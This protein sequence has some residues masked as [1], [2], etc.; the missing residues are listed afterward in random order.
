MFLTSIYSYS[1]QVNTLYFMENVPVRNSLNPAFQPLNDFY[2]G[3]PVL[4]LTQFSLSNNSFVLNDVI[5]KDAV[6]NPITFLHPN[7]DKLLFLNAINNS[8]NSNTD[9][10]VNLL[11]FGFRTGRAYWSLSVNERFTTRTSIPSDIFKFMLFG[12]PELNQNSFDFSSLSLN[13]TA[14]TE[15]GLG[16]SIKLNNKWSV[17]GKLKI[18][19]GTANISLINENLNF[20]ANT[21]EWVLKGNGTIKYS[22]PIDLNGNGIQTLNPIFPTSIIDYLKPSGY[23][24]GIDVGATFQ[25]VENL[26]FSLAVVDLGMIS[27]N[28]NLKKLGYNV[29]FKYTGIDSLGLN[30]TLNIDDYASSLLNDLQNSYSDSIESS[31]KLYSTCLSPKLNVGVEYGFFQ[32]KLSL[33]LLSRTLLESNKLFE[34]L[35]ASINGR[36][37]NWFNLSASYSVINGRMSNIGAGIGLRAGFLN[38]FLT[39]DYIPLNYIP[40]PLNKISSSLP[41]YS[42]LIPSNTKGFNFALG[43]N[44]VLGNRKDADKDGVD[45]KRDLCPGTPK[46]VKVNKDGCPVDTDGDGV[47]DYLDKCAKTPP[48]ASKQVDEFGCPLDTDKD[49]VPDYLDKCPQSPESA[50]GY[51]D[52]NG[53]ENDSDKDGKPDWLDKCPD[54]PLGV[55]VDSVGCPLDSDKDGIYDTVDKCPDTALKAKGMVDE[56]GCPK[57]S[58]GDGVPDYLDLCPDVKGVIANNGCEE[59]IGKPVGNLVEKPVQTLVEREKIQRILK[60]LFQKALQGIWFDSGSDRIVPGSYKIL[61]QIAGVLVANP[62]YI[63]EI[64][65][66]TD[67][68]GR[69]ESNLLL[70]KKRAQ[71]VMKYFISKG[72][73]SGRLN[74]NGYGEKFPVTDNTTAVGRG[75][76]RRVEFIVSYEEITFE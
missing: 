16:Y 19:M 11:D 60:S 9:F 44:L 73:D 36:P 29:D 8:F 56:N 51:V 46:N 35:T 58:D 74:A 14:F 6:G 39:A 50:K 26:N 41:T 23:G 57:D 33:G 76:N 31:A 55:E 71:A 43:L 12:T 72:V 62:T 53:C 15:A 61:N 38:W 34:E 24:V 49:G 47:P 63:I 27:W 25:P 68:V 21:D 7:G 3:L 1:Q 20:D 10:Q 65:G 5:Y 48:E 67:N 32:N 52:A 30:S 13:A 54:T 2:L 22:S 28:K 42:A 45:D 59:V 18:L 69:P 64:R 66:Y 37:V 40:L 70:S 17:G 75:M 4:G